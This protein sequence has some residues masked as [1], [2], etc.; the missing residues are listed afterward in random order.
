MLDQLGSPR[1]VVFDMDGTL[2]ESER[3]ARA[4]FLAA[5]ADVGWPDVDIA[6]YNQC[7]GAT[8][9]RTREILLAGYG[10]GFPVDE[11][12]AHWSRRYHSHID[13]HALD[14]KPGI[15][16]LLETL[17]AQQIPIALATSSRRPTALKKLERAGLL[18]F[19]QTMVCGGEVS[20]GKPHPEPYIK[21]VEEIVRRPD[22]CWALEDSDS[23]V[24]S[25]FAAGLQVIQIP[26]ELAPSPEV[27]GLGHVILADATPLAGLLS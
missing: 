12:E 4:C 17:H 1:G 22:E 10:A 26:D 23:G 14:I 3:L 27:Q 8:F 21:A 5:C 2:L 16:Q 15:V 7:V 11:M 19:F 13:H 9:A 6:V 25:A 24:R 18:H 20:Q